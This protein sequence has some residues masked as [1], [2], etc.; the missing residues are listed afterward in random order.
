MKFNLLL[1]NDLE[2][3]LDK[4]S[5]INESLVSWSFDLKVLEENLRSK[6]GKCFIDDILIL[7]LRHH[8]CRTIKVGFNGKKSNTTK[9]WNSFVSNKL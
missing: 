3:F 1:S 4:H 5:E 6:E 9:S 8:N 7:A 2:A